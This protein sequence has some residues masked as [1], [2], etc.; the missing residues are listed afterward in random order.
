MRGAMRQLGIVVSLLMLVGWTAGCTSSGS[1]VGGDGMAG[2]LSGLEAEGVVTMASGAAMQSFL[3]E[4][5]QEFVLSDGQVLQIFEY[6]SQAGAALDVSR[7]NASGN[8]VF[9]PPHFYRRGKVI[10]VYFGNNPVVE[11]ALVNVLG[12]RL[13]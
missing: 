12:P 3:M 8:N 7:I 4:S 1:A 2:I 10:A 5:G 6:D 11:Q 13:M 9:S